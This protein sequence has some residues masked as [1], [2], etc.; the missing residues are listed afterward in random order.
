MDIIQIV[1]G[2]VREAFNS[3]EDLYN[4]RMKICRK[5]AIFKKDL[6]GICNHSLWVNPE[7]N[8]SSFKEQEGFYRGCGCRLSAKTRIPDASCPAN[9]W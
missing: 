7:T 1:N 2:H 5:C 8:K 9:K 6:G 3:G 4:K